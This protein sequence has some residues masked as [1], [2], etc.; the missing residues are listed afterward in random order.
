MAH[1]WMHYE[2]LAAVYFRSSADGSGNIMHFLS[3]PGNRRIAKAHFDLLTNI[4][5][6]DRMH[7]KMQNSEKHFFE[8]Y[9]KKGLLFDGLQYGS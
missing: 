2:T 3:V 1:F 5:W 8:G 6:A 4:Q 9:E 7:V